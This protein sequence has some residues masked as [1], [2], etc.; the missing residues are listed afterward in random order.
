M[1]K[2]QNDYNGS[3]GEAKEVVVEQ[4]LTA[5]QLSSSQ[6][7]HIL[8]YFTVYIPKITVKYVTKAV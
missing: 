1:V 7:R 8:A 6:K 5:E 3:Q 2:S 4:I